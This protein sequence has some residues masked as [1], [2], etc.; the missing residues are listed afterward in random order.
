MEKINNYSLSIRRGKN[1]FSPIEWTKLDMNEDKNANP[2]SLEAIDSFTSKITGFELITEVVNENFFSEDDY[3]SSIEI[4]YHDNGGTRILPE[5]PCFKED[6]EFLDV[7]NIADYII[8]N[9]T[10]LQLI[11]KLFNYLNKTAKVEDH[12]YYKFVRLLNY[13][14]EII[15]EGNKEKLEALNKLIENYLHSLNYSEIRRIGMYI[16]KKLI[17]QKIIEEDKKLIYNND[18]R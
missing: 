9:L 16:S 18:N 2:Y 8:A 12:D 1:S 7:N 14:R 3:I 6:S 11:N 5:G 4:I 17:D 15:K 13:S 10:D